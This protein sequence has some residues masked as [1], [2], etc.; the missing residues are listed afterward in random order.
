MEDVAAGLSERE[1]SKEDL[2]DVGRMAMDLLKVESLAY[3]LVG[4]ADHSVVRS[5]RM[6]SAM[7]KAFASEALHRVLTRAERV[8]SPAWALKSKEL[9]KRRRDARVITIYEGT[10]EIQRFLLL[11]DMIESL[12]PG[13][14]GEDD[15][16]VGKGA[17]SLVSQLRASVLKTVDALRDDLG[18]ASW[19]QAH[20]QSFAFPL[21]EQMMESAALTALQ[22]RLGVAQSLLGGKDSDP[23]LQF[24]HDSLA[25]SASDGLRRFDRFLESYRAERERIRLGHDATHQAIA[26]RALLRAA[27]AENAAATPRAPAREGVL[28]IA[29]IVVTEPVQAP[30]PRVRYGRV[31]EH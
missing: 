18:S 5:F 23:R 28:R 9:E 20:L 16:T 27:A 12:E 25:L 24:L 6:E 14:R 19:Q 4:L 31:R 3:H 7:G 10:S 11:K 26:D 15:I 29:V 1:P 13:V 22:R 21:V 8:L 2:V 30:Q 17:Q